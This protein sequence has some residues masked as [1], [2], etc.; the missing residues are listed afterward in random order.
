[1]RRDAIDELW[2]SAQEPEL[3]KV[4]KTK[5]RKPRT[6]EKAARVIERETVIVVGEGW[7]VT[8]RDG[9]VEVTA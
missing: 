3:P 6:T 4:G 1:M 5:Q 8:V 2:D 7:R 9:V